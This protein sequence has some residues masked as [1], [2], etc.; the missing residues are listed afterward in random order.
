MGKIPNPYFY[1]L[2]RYATQDS[3]RLFDTQESDFIGNRKIATVE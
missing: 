1:Y 2:L 3:V